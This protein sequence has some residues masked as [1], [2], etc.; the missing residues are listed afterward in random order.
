MKLTKG[1]FDGLVRAVRAVGDLFEG[2]FTNLDNSSQIEALTAHS[3]IERRPVGQKASAFHRHFLPLRK[4]LITLLAE[5]YRRFFKLALAHASA[6][7][8]SVDMWTQVQLQPALRVA[9]HWIREWYIL[10][11]E[12]ENHQLRHLG[13]M[14]FIP[15][16]T[17]SMEI[18]T[19][20]PPLPPSASWHAPAWL[21][22]VSPLLGIG[23]LKT[24]HVP[25]RDS[26]QKLGS[27]HTRLLLMGAKRA[28]LWDLAAAIETVRNEEI[29]AAGAIPTVTAEAQTEEQNQRKGS[30]PGLKGI[31]GLGPKKTDLSSY[32]D[33]LTEKQQLAFSLK[34]EYGLGIAEIASRMGINHKTAYEHIEAAHNKINQARSNE[35][36]KDHRFKSEDE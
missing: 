7:E 27:A 13:S 26:E 35:K 36:R 18:P 5:S 4:E 19:A 30:K 29:A 33:N 10:A 8:T 20:V 14:P 31:E 21:F 32:M 12:G 9:L 28:F 24:E 15:G 34:F 25:A 11:C 2:A 17:V 6:L 23:P 22:E 3:E 1:S 16:Q